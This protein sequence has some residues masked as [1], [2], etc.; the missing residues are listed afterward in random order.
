MKTKP[1]E[2]KKHE[3]YERAD[4]RVT[5]LIWASLSIAL[6]MAV[7]VGG[8]WYLQRFYAANPPQNSV[9]MPFV[10]AQPKPVLPRLQIDPPVDM[11]NFR[12]KEDSILTGYAWV[13]R[14]S[15]IARIPVDRAMELLLAQGIPVSATPH[16]D[17]AKNSVIQQ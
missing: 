9:S 2:T 10:T 7:G 14:D 16:T 11:I 17:L 3:G 8:M 1:D 13:S 6:L 5:P 15:G 4:A 12:V